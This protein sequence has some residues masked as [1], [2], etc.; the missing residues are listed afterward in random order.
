MKKI[1]KS[2]VL[3][4]ALSVAGMMGTA[5]A[6]SPVIIKFA[7][8]VADNTPKGQ[9]ANL[10]KQKAEE[11]LGDK[12][13]VDV[14]PNSSLYGDG[15]EMDALLS[16]D[17]QLLAP[18]LSKLEHYQQKLQLF[19]LPF[20]FENM[21]A[22]DRFQHSDAGV[23]LLKSMEDKNITGLAYWHNGM[24]QLSSNKA[25]RVPRDARGLR[26]RVQ[27]SNVLEEQFKALRANPRKIAFAEVYQALQ[28]GVV[29]GAENTYSNIYSQKVHEVQEFITESNHGIIDYMVITNS[30]FWNGL[31]ADIRTA[32]EEVMAEVTVEVNQMA[33]EL[34][35]GDKAKI[36]EAGTTEIINITPEQRN[37]WR[38]TVQPVWKKF[39]DQIGADLIEAASAANES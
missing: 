39:E 4:V 22:L 25:L 36:I 33:Q 32:L 34:N 7:H 31:D 8:V 15:Q 24:K 18:S 19:D 21:A 26:F 9:G 28:T 14:Y 20:L 12:V 6:Q 5:Q 11:R 30:D 1:F 29:N 3:P 2:L 27:A 37:E 35:D 10:F 38:E 17:V 13:R 23:E 16:N